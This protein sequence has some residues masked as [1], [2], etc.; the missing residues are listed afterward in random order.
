MAQKIR[1]ALLAT[2]MASGLLLSN[3]P[4]YA[5]PLVEESA[6]Q[7]AGV[8]TSAAVQEVAEDSAVP[9]PAVSAI[10]PQAPAKEAPQ[11][12]L[13][14]PVDE[15][16]IQDEPPV[17]PVEGN[18]PTTGA[19]E[20][21]SVGDE[22]ATGTPSAIDAP[23]E[24]SGEP[25][26]KDS[27]ESGRAEVEQETVDADGPSRGAT[28]TAETTAPAGSDGAAAETS[29]TAKESTVAETATEE[30][31]ESASEIDIEALASFDELLE[32]IETPP[33]SEDWTEEQWND[34]L[35]TAEGQEFTEAILDALSETEEFS[36]I[37]DIVLD[38]V[39]TEDLG[40]LEELKEY[41]LELFGGN[42]EWAMEAY[43]GM[44]AELRAEGFDVDDWTKAQKPS[45]NTP[46]VVP[47]EKP[48][49]EVKPAIKPAGNVKPV[50]DK[51]P[52]AEAVVKPVAQAKA[53]ELAETGSN[54]VLLM[55]GAGMLLVIGGVFALRM[56][57]K[58]R[59]H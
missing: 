58:P 49:P 25:S 41:L 54:G 11:M 59:A 33:G 2:A 37:F 23:E 39:E 24:A 17:A 3:A 40:Y 36:V 29:K 10:D 52:M 26:G 57:R 46:P 32:G 5:A 31:S 35:P 9:A 28:G 14:V 48:K 19:D 4:A 6:S 50:V 22:G 42:E 44:A 12:D 18:T 30:V 16:G 38:F 47:S 56:R 51:K 7:D 53:Q 1:T 21:P 27:D 43:N 15:A 34:Y 55:G 13:A 8:D 45:E 20:T